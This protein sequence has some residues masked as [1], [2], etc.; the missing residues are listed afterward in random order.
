MMHRHKAISSSEDRC[1]SGGAK[2][3]AAAGGIE[4]TERCA[5]G[6]ERIVYSNGGHVDVGRWHVPVE[7]DADDF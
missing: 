4:W 2:N 7:R 5:C 6:S 3:Q 1:Y